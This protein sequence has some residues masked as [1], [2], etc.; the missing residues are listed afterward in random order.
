MDLKPVKLGKSIELKYIPFAELAIPWNVCVEAVKPTRE[1]C[2]KESGTSPYGKGT[3][4]GSRVP[5][6]VRLSDLDA[7]K[8]SIG[9]FGLLKP[10]EVAELPERLDFFYG[11]GKYVIIDGQRRYFAIREMLKLPTEH[12]EMKQKDSLRTNSGHDQI[13][14]GEVQAQEQFDR[15]NICNYVLIPCLVYPY[16]TFLQMVRHTIEDKRFSVKPSK[17]TLELAEKMRA[18]GVQDLSPEDLSDL[19]ETRGRIKED[20]EAI[21]KTLLEIRNRI[22][23]KEESEKIEQT[24]MVETH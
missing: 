17:D 8:Y 6:T 2:T 22:K 23:G 9:Q 4:K 20:R 19:W 24:T 15:L 11:N 7:L 1:G 18:E 16:T 10:F 13:N 21:E 3:A 12:D 5:K 14:N